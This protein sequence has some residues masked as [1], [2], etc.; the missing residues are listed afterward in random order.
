MP[1]NTIQFQR[2]LGLDEFL[3]KYGTEDQCEQALY[4]HRWPTVLNCTE[5]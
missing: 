1:K 2:G 3:E 5:I 4:Q